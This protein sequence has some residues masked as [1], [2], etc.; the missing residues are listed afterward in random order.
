MAARPGMTWHGEHRSQAPVP[1]QALENTRLPQRL[2]LLPAPAPWLLPPTHAVLC[3]G[4]AVGMQPGCCRYHRQV[5]CKTIGA[6]VSAKRQHHPVS[7]SGCL[8]ASWL[9][10]G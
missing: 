7:S 4:D 8:A 6:T 1:A 9:T 2:P 5:F 3:I 10:T